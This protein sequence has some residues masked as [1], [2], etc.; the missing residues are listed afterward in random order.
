VSRPSSL[1]SRIALVAAALLAA[2]AAAA[3]AVRALGLAASARDWLGFDFVPP[4][5]SAGEALAVGA[6]NLRLAAAVLLGALLVRAR[7]ATRPALDVVAGV[8]GLLNAGV[9]GVALGAWGGPLLEAVVVHGALEFTAFAIAGG[10]YLAARASE[11]EVRRLAGA[12]AACAGL[13]AAAAA[14]ETYVPLG[15]D[16]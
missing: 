6:G 3:V 12:T 8:L 7:P 16:P 9:T 11:L 15:G 4:R 5:A 1:R 2:I 14:V 10:A 13:L